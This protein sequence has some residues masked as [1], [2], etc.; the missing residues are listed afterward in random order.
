M[1]WGCGWYDCEE[2]GGKDTLYVEVHT[3]CPAENVVCKKCGWGYSVDENGL[4]TEKAPKM[5]EVPVSMLRPI[6]ELPLEF[7]ST[8]KKRGKEVN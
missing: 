3:R 6:E 5:I 1:S 7:K 8:T 4:K 2:C